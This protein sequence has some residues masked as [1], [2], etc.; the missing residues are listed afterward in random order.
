MLLNIA[1]GSNELG[2]EGGR[3]G[4]RG[5]RVKNV[6]PF[7]ILYIYKLLLTTFLYFIKSRVIY[8]V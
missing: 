7:Y 5:R 4:E 8:V 6:L 2:V 3:G 1:E